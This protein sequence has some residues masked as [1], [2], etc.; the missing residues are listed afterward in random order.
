[1]SSSRSLKGLTARVDEM[2]AR[3][4]AMNQRVS[5]CCSNF[6]DVKRYVDDNIAD[7]KSISV[8]ISIECFPDPYFVL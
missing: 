2:E 7:C 1:M 8:S 5:E 3:I 6:E 4:Q